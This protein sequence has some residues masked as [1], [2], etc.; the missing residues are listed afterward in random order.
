M[1]GTG[2]Y[3]IAE[4]VNADCADDPECL[5]AEDADALMAACEQV[6]DAVVADDAAGTVTFNLIQSWAPFLGTLAQSWGAVLD[7]DW[8]IA[9]NAWDGDCAT[10]QNYYGI[11]SENSPLRDVVNG[12]GPYMLDHWTPGEEVVFVANP[13]YWR[14]A[15][16]VPLFEG[17]PT[18]PSVP[19]IVKRGVTEWGTRFA[20]MQAGDADFTDVP[21][22]NVSQI[23]P[24]VGE[25][26]TWN[27][28]TMTHD[29]AATE[30]PDGP[31]RLFTG[32][33][34]TNRT[35]AM[36]VFDINV[37]GGNPYVG[38]GELDGNGIP[39][40]F[41]SDVHVRKAFNYCFDW[42]A[43]IQDA[44]EG[45]AVQGVGY[46]IPG[47]IGY[48]QNGPKYSYDPEKCKEEMDLAWDGKVAE[49]GFRMQVAYNT[50]NVTRQTIAEILQTTFAE[51]DP[52][53]TI[54]II[55]L[56]WPS[57]LAAIRGSR[58]P[59]YISGWQEDIHDPHNWAQPFLVGTYAARQVLPEDISR[60]A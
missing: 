51:V 10:W 32:H 17:G 16:N 19:R 30:N 52:K 34:S 40:D 59:L 29:C 22:Q 58:L 8:A 23:D 56:P 18:A 50:G 5:Q 57:F 26:C 41:F 3:D 48:D 37:E 46:L 25:L 28:D 24:L 15:Q 38:S 31:F 47:M 11:T 6:M 44:L 20:M 7:K 36:F 60:Q 39:A 43:F 55:G 9:N 14:A 1:F 33:P 2:T 54:E 49:V 53:Y 13:D 42:E 4:L 35:D 27:A 21:R 12:T 45:E